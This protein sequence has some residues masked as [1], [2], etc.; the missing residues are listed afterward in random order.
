MR[1]VGRGALVRNV[2]VIEYLLKFRAKLASNVPPNYFDFKVGGLWRV[3]NKKFRCFRRRLVVPLEHPQPRYAGEV[4]SKNRHVVPASDP[5]VFYRSG[6]V[7]FSA[8]ELFHSL[9]VRLFLYWLSV[10]FSFGALL[11]GPSLGH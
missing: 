1:R 11:A 10:C 4:V 9:V 5:R 6:Q 8:A 2:E 7:H 3:G